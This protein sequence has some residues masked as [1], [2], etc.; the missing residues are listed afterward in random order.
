[1]AEAP[2]QRGAPGAL[3]SL[4]TWAPAAAVFLAFV[5]AFAHFTV[6]D[7]YISLRY[8][9]N[10]ARGDG[11][12]FN[13]GERVEGYTNFLWN[14]LAASAIALG[15]PPLTT[16]KILG[17]AC[18]LSLFPLAAAMARALRPAAGLGAALAPALLALSPCIAVWAVAGLETCLFSALVTATLLAY[19][20]YRDGQARGVWWGILAAFAVLTRPEGALVFTLLG[21][22]ELTRA[23]RERR[24]SCLIPLI[25]F[26]LI[27]TP[28][29]VWRLWYFGDWLPNTFR[30]KVGGF[31]LDRLLSGGRYL[32]EFARSYFG[33]PALL[34]LPVLAVLKASKSSAVRVTVAVVA[35]YAAYV[36]LVGSDWMPQFRFLIPVMPLLAALLGEGALVLAQTLHS[37]TTPQRRWLLRV[38]A[39]AAVAAVVAPAAFMT[40]YGFRS[41]DSPRF[42]A[43]GLDLEYHS[44]TTS[45]FVA[46]GHLLRDV[47]QPGETLATRAA[48]AIPYL[49]EV[50]T[51]DLFG[52]V[53]RDLAGK[54]PQEIADYTFEV[55]RPTFIESASGEIFAPGGV[56]T[57]PRFRR[58][59]R[60]LGPSGPPADIWVR[61]DR[62]SDRA[63]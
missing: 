53:T 10:L 11:L 15:L 58:D 7:T 6:D 27:V 9:A 44:R 49:S 3:S 30:A 37:H 57:D 24:A 42:A 59:Y 50:Q 39:A 22:I 12:V 55:Y 46:A 18:G 54:T 8:A 25:G 29:M 4:L 16:V 5:L 51:L 31:S 45:R 13:P 14:I 36:A 60:Q 38:A 63:G 28:Y 56:G 19:L 17:V 43:Y 21:G 23:V 32:L 2:Q 20:R 62:A 1:M 34:V 40:A 26:A 52:L 41:V 48:G 47:A 33:L 61:R 35:A